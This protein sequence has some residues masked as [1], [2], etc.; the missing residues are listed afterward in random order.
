[1]VIGA[2][3]Y[4]PRFLGIKRERV[5]DGRKYHFMYATETKA[6]AQKKAE[7]ARK[8]LGRD[9]RVAK[10]PRL[11]VAQKKAWGYKDSPKYVVYAAERYAKSY[12]GARY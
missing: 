7:Y 4:G 10:A 1:M 12:R 5:F 3:E 9:C 8:Y 2:P 6:D 11:T